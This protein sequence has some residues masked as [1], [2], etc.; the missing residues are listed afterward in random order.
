MPFANQI[1]SFAQSGT[2]FQNLGDIVLQGPKSAPNYPQGYI[3]QYENH[4]GP[5][6]VKPSMSDR[7][8][9]PVF[10]TSTSGN[11]NYI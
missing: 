5:T 7:F 1:F 6:G 3:I 2:P 4:V 10:I 8:L 9:R 11:A